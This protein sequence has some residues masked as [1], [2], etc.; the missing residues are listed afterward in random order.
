MTVPTGMVW[1]FSYLSSVLNSKLFL[2][3][4]KISPDMRIVE[5]LRIQQLNPYF[6]ASRLYP[7]LYPLTLSIYEVEEGAPMP[8]D[9]IEDEEGY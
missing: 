9:F 1:S 8:G 4:I 6:Y 2:N 5:F 3:S 7:K